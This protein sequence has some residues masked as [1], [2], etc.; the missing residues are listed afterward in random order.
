MVHVYVSMCLC[1]CMWE[2]ACKS[3]FCAYVIGCESHKL[4]DEMKRDETYVSSGDTSLLM[5]QKVKIHSLIQDV[6]NGG[7]DAM[8]CKCEHSA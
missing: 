8:T 6:A 5:T 2:C 1:E 4:I 7:Y 3:D